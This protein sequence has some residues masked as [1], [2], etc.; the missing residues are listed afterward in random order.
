M[1]P[2]RYALL[3]L[4]HPRSAWFTEL[5]RWATS[6][7]VP[8]D[9]VRCVSAEEVRA[10]LSSSRPY[11]ALLVDARAVGLDRD[12][13]DAAH[14]AGSAA[15]RRGRTRRRA[16]LA[17]AGRR[18]RPGRAARP[19]RAP[20]RARATRRLTGTRRSPIPAPPARPR[21][22]WRGRLV[23]VTGG[24]G[25]GSSLLAMALAQALGDDARNAGHV[26]LAD[27]ALVADQAMLHGSPDIVPGVSELVEAHRSGRPDAAAVR[28][29][30]FDVAGR[31]YDLLLGLRRRRDWAALRPRAVEAA[32]ASLLSTYR[33]VVADTDPDVDGEEACGSIEVEERNVL[34][35]TA[36]ALADAVVVVGTGDTKGLHRMVRVVA[37]LVEHG[38]APGRLLPVLNRAPRAPRARAEL[39]RAFAA[40][41][42]GFLDA[43][44]VASPIYLGRQRGVEEALRDGAR[45]PGSLGPSLRGAVD[46]VV[47]RSPRRPGDPAPGAHR[48]LGRGVVGALVRRT[49]RG[50][51]RRLTS[52]GVRCRGGAPDPQPGGTATRCVTSLKL[53]REGTGPP[54]RIRE[55]DA[56]STYIRQLT[57]GPTPNAQAIAALIGDTWVNTATSSAAE[58]RASAAHAA[59]D[60]GL[61]PRQAL[62]ARRAEVVVDPPTGPGLG[63]DPADRQ[64]VPLAVVELDPAI[65]DLDREAELLG[66]RRGRLQGAAQRARD[67]PVDLADRG[68]DRR[69][70]ELARPD[71]ATW[72]TRPWSRPEALAVVRPWRTRISMTSRGYGE[73]LTC[74]A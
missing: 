14:A 70:L 42:G 57:D 4:A 55:I 72:S 15:L 12:L 48:P 22:G 43:G 16:G 10:R 17:G 45:L 7:T 6:G 52:P 69:G 68:G 62:P 64:L 32:L 19:R 54:R 3:G 73:R 24:G 56:C 46:A 47:S 13:V 50:P 37:D 9:F 71:R 26:L 44:R 49:R 34:A 38:V 18:R 74:G 63:G 59:C 36:T 35:R 20:R 28:A 60:P 8:A 40:L 21:E 53:T 51:G 5:G 23:A 33:H 11:S 65:V 41:V 1:A 31:G 29:T 66:E 27:L 2:A 61:K 67:D 30:T 25:T 58:S 39:T